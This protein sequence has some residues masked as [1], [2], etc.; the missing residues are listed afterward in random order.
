MDEE[1]QKIIEEQ[2]KKLPEDVRQAIISVDYKTRLQEITQ[3]QKL[4]IDKASKLEMETTLVMIGLEPLADYI[5]N[6]QRELEIPLVRAKEIATDVNKNIFQTIRGSLQAM[7]EE[8]GTSIPNKELKEN[9]VGWGNVKNEE[10][11]ID[12]DR[13]QVLNEIENPEMIRDGNQSMNFKPEAPKQAGTTA[14]EIKPAQEIET[15]PGQG[16][17]DVARSTDMDILTAKMTG[18]TTTSQQIINTKPESKLPEIKK[19]PFS[20]VDP[21]REE[22]K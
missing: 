19:R 21:Y 5:D 14:I 13:N 2:M 22:I 4:L 17:K 7:N 16:V 12:L 11:E 15:I 10:G 20:G 18:A 3:R 6:L 8:S 1:S 9:Y